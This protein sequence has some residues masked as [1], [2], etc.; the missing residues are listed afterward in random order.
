[1]C[2]GTTKCDGTCSVATPADLGKSCGM[3]GGTTRCDGTCS[4]ATPG[5]YGKACGNCGGVMGCSEC[6][7]KDPADFGKKCG[8]CGGTTKCDGT[9]TV[10]TPPDYGTV[11]NLIAQTITLNCCGETQTGTV[12]GNCSTGWVLDSVQ[13]A[14]GTLG[15]FDATCFAG[16]ESSAWTVSKEFTCAAQV[17]LVNTGTANG[18]CQVNINERRA[19]DP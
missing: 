15:G 10:A 7:V 1:M 4:V 11:R 5:D 13:I 2:G 19:C 6:S 8:S 12:G 17:Q 9:C 14:N 3:C 18:V 16:D